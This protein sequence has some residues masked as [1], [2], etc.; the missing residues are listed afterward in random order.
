MIIWSCAEETKHI[1]L[2]HKMADITSCWQNILLS[3]EWWKDHIL[4]YTDLCI[5]VTI[6]DTW[7]YFCMFTESEL[8]FVSIVS[9]TMVETGSNVIWPQNDG[10]RVFQAMQPWC[11]FSIES[12]SHS[13]SSK[14]NPC[15]LLSLFKTNKLSAYLSC[16]AEKTVRQ[17]QVSASNSTDVA[18]S[19]RWL[20]TPFFSTS[21][22]H[23]VA[24]FFLSFWHSWHT[25]CSAHQ[26][27]FSLP[28]SA[29]VYQSVPRSHALSD[30]AN[31]C[32]CWKKRQPNCVHV[33]VLCIT[34]L[35]VWNCD[36]QGFFFFLHIFYI[37]PSQLPSSYERCILS[38][39]HTRYFEYCSRLY[40]CSGLV[41][42]FFLSITYDTSTFKKP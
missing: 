8:A 22:F 24:S 11:S 41:G 3:T 7:K 12:L 14:S 21:F 30:I 29:F 13:L 42:F 26:L 18:K 28:A 23:L 5:L 9:T 36:L 40:M 35:R 34:K 1:T 6:W 33:C 15:F 10:A 16:H 37:T 20:A 27:S 2:E 25:F 32:P 17:F 39:I 19:N 4:M 38:P 31:V